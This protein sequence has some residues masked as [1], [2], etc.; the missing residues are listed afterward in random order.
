LGELNK[1]GKEW[2]IAE[3]YLDDIK[4]MTEKEKARYFKGK[5][6]L[7]MMNSNIYNKM[8][9]SRKNKGADQGRKLF[10]VQDG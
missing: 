6:T 9:E 3:A 4:G 8:V 1:Q 10:I 7:G 2:A 5:E